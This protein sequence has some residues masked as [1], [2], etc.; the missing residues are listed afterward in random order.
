MSFT[1]EK[2][3][4]VGVL[5][6]FAYLQET[7]ETQFALTSYTDLK[8]RENGFEF[9]FDDRFMNKWVKGLNE[10]EQQ[11]YHFYQSRLN[12]QQRELLVKY[13]DRR[14]IFHVYLT[15]DGDWYQAT[16]IA[17]SIE[18][19]DNEHFLLK[20]EIDLDE[21]QPPIIAFDPEVHGLEIDLG[22]PALKLELNHEFTP[23]QPSDS[24]GISLY[25]YFRFLKVRE[26]NVAVDVKNVRNLIIQNNDGVF[27]ADAPFL[28]FGDE[29]DVGETFYIGSR[30]IFQK[31]LENLTINYSWGS[32]PEDTF[33]FHYLGYQPFPKLEKD[34]Y[35]A[36]NDADELQE[37]V[38]SQLTRSEDFSFELKLLK[39][40]SW[41]NFTIPARFHLFPNSQ[42]GKPVSDVS[43]ELN[44]SPSPLTASEI[45]EELEELN[46]NTNAGFMQLSL[47]PGKL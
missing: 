23:L 2:N 4:L 22:V 32:L 37:K 25:H 40:R 5:E 1:C 26:V 17:F 11:I 10:Y 36:F 6:D 33:G 7:V 12:L 14:S 18:D 42:S 20:L 21:S 45:S 35:D 3:S 24:T 39:N 19:V 46:I 30:E 28:P 34:N 27:G 16:E 29:P 13:A 31:D 8:L 47:K 41:Q 9:V 44:L 38:V 43:L 15:I